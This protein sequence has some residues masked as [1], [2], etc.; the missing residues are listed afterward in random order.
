MKINT[1]GS[2]LGA[3][4]L[5]SGGGVVRSACGF[6][7]GC[8]RQSFGVGFSF[9][10]ELLASIFALEWAYAMGWRRVWLEV[11]STEVVRQ[12]TS[13][14]PVVHSRL[15]SRWSRVLDYIQHMDF[16]ITHIYREGNQVANFLAS[17][18]ME[19]GWWPCAHPKIMGL[20]NQDLFFSHCRRVFK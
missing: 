2:A 9:E 8:F 18:V 3:P 19:D 15:R 4:G 17:S 14:S 13:K 1:D 12:F 20:L 10:A 16:Q 5:I 6:V 11:D 7:L